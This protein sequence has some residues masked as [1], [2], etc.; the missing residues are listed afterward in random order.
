MQQSFLKFLLLCRI[1]TAQHASGITMP[2]IRSPSN[3]LCSLWFPYECEGRSVLSRGPTTAE[4][5]ST[6][7]FIRKPE[8]VEQCLYDKAIKILRLIVASSWLF[9]LSTK[10][11]SNT[12]VLR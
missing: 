8:T 2:I 4:N 7:T 3:C 6:S 1:D 10:L 11:S 9:Y 12:T 5:T